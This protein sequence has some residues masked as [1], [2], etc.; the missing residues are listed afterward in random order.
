[1]THA[2]PAS[3][4]DTTPMGVGCRPT[5][6]RHLQEGSPGLLERLVH[7]LARAL[8]SA[9]GRLAGNGRTVENNSWFGAGGLGN[10]IITTAKRIPG[11]PRHRDRILRWYHIGNVFGRSARGRYE[12]RAANDASHAAAAGSAGGNF[13]GSPRAESGTLCTGC[14]NDGR[15]SAT[16]CLAQFRRV[17]GVLPVAADHR[18]GVP[19]DAFDFVASSTRPNRRAARCLT[20]FRGRLRNR[21]AAYGRVEATAESLAVFGW[22]LAFWLL[23]LGGG[24]LLAGSSSVFAHI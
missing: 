3:R 18:G 12:I 20:A 19:G 5:S 13:A 23:L 17:V 4:D 2:E 7:A 11:R 8:V 21:L 16:H 15:C 6:I 14:P 24:E 9:R 1:M 22:W 10:I